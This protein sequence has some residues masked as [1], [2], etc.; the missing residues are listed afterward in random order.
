MRAVNLLPEKHRPRRPSG[1]QRGSSYVVLG[2]L[3]AI[4]VAVLVYVLTANSINQAQTDIAAAKDETARAN[5]QA[6]QLGAYGDFAKVKVQ[7]VEAVKQLASSRM[8][9]ERMVRELAHVLPNGVWIQNASAADSAADAATAGAG[10]TSSASSSSSGAPTADGPSLT[11][12]GCAT[13]QRTVADTL[14]RLRELQGASDVKLDHSAAPVDSGT[15][16]G[17][18]AG[19]ASSTGTGDCGKTDGKPNYEF[20]AIVSFEPSSDQ[21]DKPGSVPERLGGG[22]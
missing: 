7:R 20:Q 2:V 19:A 22:Q 17:S 21:T 3:G 15:T 9:W 4:V 5:A 16:S 13:D 6:Q 8:D 11:I 1:G 14:V 12:Q 10:S 18:G